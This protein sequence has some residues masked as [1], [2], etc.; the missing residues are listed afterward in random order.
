MVAETMRRSAE[1]LCAVRAAYGLALLAAPRRALGGTRLGAA[2]PGALAFA[3]ILGARQLAE[4]AVLARC[5]QR[6]VLLLGAGVD[7]LHGVSMLAVCA[8][9][10]RRRRLAGASAAAAA[11]LAAWGVASAI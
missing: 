11:V 7:A 4:A 6:R 10:P 5:P 3:R 1:T 2:E 9:S 8:L